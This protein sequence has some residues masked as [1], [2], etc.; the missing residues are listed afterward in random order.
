MIGSVTNDNYRRIDDIL[1]SLNPPPKQYEK[2]KRIDPSKKLV[3]CQEWTKN[4]IKLLIEK[5][6]VDEVE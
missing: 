4:A 3:H 6:V 2:H 1:K 5:K